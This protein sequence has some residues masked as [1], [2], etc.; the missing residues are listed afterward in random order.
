MNRTEFIEHAKW[1]EPLSP[2]GACFSRIEQSW[3]SDTKNQVLVL[4]TNHPTPHYEIVL[5]SGLLFGLL[6]KRRVHLILSQGAVVQWDEARFREIYGNCLSILVDRKKRAQFLK[7]QRNQD[8]QDGLQRLKGNPL[9]FRH[10]FLSF[11]L[12]PFER[13]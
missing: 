6:G 7:K 1:V 5:L 4:L 8:F 10:W 12:K 2:L 13:S 3:S 11:W 9:K